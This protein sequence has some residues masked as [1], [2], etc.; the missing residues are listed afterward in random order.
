MAETSDLSGKAIAVFAFAAYHQLE[1]GQP[2]KSVIREDGN[3]HKA[4]E[5]AVAEL[6]ARS[7]IEVRENDLC[8]TDAGLGVLSKAVEGLKSAARDA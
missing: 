7:L 2:V 4:D 6:E 3:G 1:S 8:F 5:A